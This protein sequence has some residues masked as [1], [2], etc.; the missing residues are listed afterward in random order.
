MK[1]EIAASSSCL[2]GGGVAA[3]ISKRKPCRRGLLLLL[4]GGGSEQSSASSAGRAVT[5]AAST[6]QARAETKMKVHWRTSS[7][8]AP[9]VRRRAASRLDAGT[10]WGAVMR[11][12]GAAA[13]R[14]PPPGRPRP[15]A[16]P[17]KATYLT[18]SWQSWQLS[19]SSQGVWRAGLRGVHAP[20]PYSV[21]SCLTLCVHTSSCSRF[22]PVLFAR[23]A[24]YLTPAAVQISRSFVPTDSR[25]DCRANV[26]AC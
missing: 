13:L 3:P 21:R 20:F 24:R 4:Q 15:S 8:S 12:L 14:P 23:S 7:F 6:P 18:E 2:L 9:F 11:V 16:C 26:H 25:A 10:Y 1:R 22:G 17:G 19:E 5:T